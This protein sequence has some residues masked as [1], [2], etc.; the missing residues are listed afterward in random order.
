[1]DKP[2]KYTDEIGEFLTRLRDSGQVNMM[3]S[4]SY[5]KTGFS[6][7]FKEASDCFWYWAETLDD[8]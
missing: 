4:P 5:L 7:T 8:K 3:G 2:E 1:M 6:L